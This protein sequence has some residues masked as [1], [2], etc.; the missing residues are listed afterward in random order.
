MKTLF[1]QP[2]YGYLII[3]VCFTEEFPFTSNRA[4]W[5][6]G[7]PFLPITLLLNAKPSFG[8]PN[9]VLS[10]SPF[11]LVSWITLSA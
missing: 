5:Y 10:S 9:L 7:G 4:F 11:S 3:S 2:G 1:P 6:A 8:I